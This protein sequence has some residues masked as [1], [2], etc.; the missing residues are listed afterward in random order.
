MNDTFMNNQMILV[1]ILLKDIKTSHG[2]SPN[3]VALSLLTP[4]V[5]FFWVV[6]VGR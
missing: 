3:N 2:Y 6:V 4:R 5:I 1:K